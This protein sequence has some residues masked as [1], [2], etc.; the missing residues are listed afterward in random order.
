MKRIAA[1]VSTVLVPVAFAM[2]GIPA[3]AATPSALDVNNAV[4]K[5]VAYLDTKQNDDGTFGTDFK[6]AETSLA[7]ISYGVS[8]RG[9][10]N[11]L[12]VA[13]QAIVKKA[14]T[15]LLTQQN[16]DAASDTYGTF[17]SGEDYPT[18]FTG[19]AVS[20]LSFSKNANTGTPAAITAGRAG[21]IALF[22]GPTHKP[23]EACNTTDQWQYC[24]G[25]NYDFGTN[26]S[27]ESNTGF[28]LT[29][30][31]LSGGVPA[32]LALL[33]AGWQH[34]VQELSTNTHATQNDGGGTYLPGETY[35]PFRSNANDTGSML[36]GYGYAGVPS[37]DAGVQAGV[38]FGQDVLDVYE[39]T[40]ATRTMVYHVAAN[41]EAACVPGTDGCHWQFASGEGGYHYSMWSLSKG[42]GE[43][44]APDLSNPANFYAKIADLLVSQQAD[45]GSWPQDGRDDAS[46]IGATGFSIFALGLAAVPPPAVSAFGASSFH[47]GGTCNAVHLTWQNPNSPNYGGVMIRRRTDHA[48]A[49]PS[50]GT[51][52]VQAN[53]PTQ[54]FDDKGLAVNT[55][56]YYGAFSYDT[57]G[58][59]FGQEATATTNTTTCSD[60]VSPVTL[61]ATGGGLAGLPA[62][63]L[64]LAS[65]LGV[66]AWRRRTTTA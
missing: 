2:S 34:N 8:D 14:V 11:N 57:T 24:G 49:S 51:E 25:F 5:G 63:I 19:L 9:D 45:N 4:E 23:T 59:L 17:G 53:R 10:F 54:S 35:T 3:S 52:V 13:R 15:W 37:T 64:L 33:D 40:K 31:Q 38:K 20:A 60:G 1:I 12:S 21:L 58:Q 61:P 29:G 48:P 6:I 46:V 32:A 66:L 65:G 56:Y 26:R 16:T 22:Q 44:S 27:D 39:L 28:G 50:D 18:Y 47:S 55:T 42:L 41:E 36:F 7:L 30:L 62:G 43:Y